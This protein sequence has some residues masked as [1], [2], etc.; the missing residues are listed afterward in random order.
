MDVEWAAAGLA[1]SAAIFGAAL[2]AG[3]SLLQQ[4]R[5]AATERQRREDE[6]ERRRQ[7]RA[8]SRRLAEASSR[9]ESKIAARIV[10]VD[11]EQARARMSM[12]VRNGHYW[13]SA[14]TL[15]QDS[16]LQ[17]REKIARHLTAEEWAVVSRFFRSVASFDAGASVA[18][19]RDPSRSP[20]ELSERMSKA[21]ERAV[22]RA[23]E[24][25][26]V[27]ARFTADDP[28]PDAEELATDAD[29]PDM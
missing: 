18:R 9:D 2:A 14:Y 24:A 22:V 19:S 29:D 21:M 28:T 7:E 25:F 4:R 15:P 1:F 8:E 23:D 6:A 16:W 11:V 17:Y 27:L 5:D 20:A 3:V 13:S 12:A 26:A 10:R